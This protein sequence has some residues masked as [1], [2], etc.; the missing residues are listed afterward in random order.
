MRPF[1]TVVVCAVFAMVSGTAFGQDRARDEVRIRERTER[2]M[3]RA[4]VREGRA[5]TRS[6][7]EIARQDRARRVLDEDDRGEARSQM[8]IE[9]E[10]RNV[11]RT[12]QEEGRLRDSR[13]RDREA[14]ERIE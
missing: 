6:G 8:E 11:E 12:L 1:S 5:E 10:N 2:L 14:I 9:R 7:R 4:E 13:N 3:E